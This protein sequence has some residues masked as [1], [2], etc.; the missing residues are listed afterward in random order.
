MQWGPTCNV[1]YNGKNIKNGKKRYFDFQVQA[2]SQLLLGIKQYIYPEMHSFN[3]E[4]GTGV[5]YMKMVNQ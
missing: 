4:L 1:Y 3:T 2:S 5:I